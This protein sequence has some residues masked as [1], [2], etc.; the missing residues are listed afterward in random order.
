MSSSRLSVGV[1]LL[2][3]QLSLV[4][5][6]GGSSSNPGDGGST[7]PPP[8]VAGHC[9]DYRVGRKNPYFGDLHTHTSYSLDAYFFNAVND[10]R[11]AHRFAKGENGGLPGLGSNDPYTK[12]RDVTIGRPLD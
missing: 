2:A 9:A 3:I 10:P 11:A 1:V 7:P 12:G 4:A 6:N 5:C 8:P